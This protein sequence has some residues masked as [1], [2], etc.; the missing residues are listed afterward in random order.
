MKRILS[1]VLALSLL[2]CACGNETQ[3]QSR[4][5]ALP[6]DELA[7]A[8]I[9]YLGVEVSELENVN[10][11]YAQDALEGFAE[12]YYGLSG[13]DYDD[14][15]LY[16]KGGKEAF[17]ISIFRLTQS[18]DGKY[19]EAALEEYRL[20]R[21]GDFFGY[22][23]EQAEIVENSLVCVYGGYAAVLIC[24][25]A[26]SAR[27]AFKAA[28]DGEKMQGSIST[29]EPVQSPEPEQTTEPTQTPQAENTG[30]EFPDYWAAFVPPGIDNMNIWDASHVVS[31]VKTGSDEGLNKKDKK[32]YTATVEILDGIISPGMT[33]LEMEWAVYSWLTLNAEYDYRHYEI[34]NSAP[35]DS[36]KPHGP[37]VEGTA[38]C[39]GFAT[40][41]QFFMDILDIEC[42]TVVGAAFSS[43][44]DHAWNMVRIDGEW[45]CVDATW[46]LS[47][48]ASPE[49]CCYFNVSS[50]WM[51]MTDHQW[52]YENVPIALTNMDV[53]LPA[54]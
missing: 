43:R 11:T 22:A 18:A 3:T 37:I 5:E 29:S 9:S 36:Y 7:R 49:N 34:P 10:S 30:A 20:S 14:C 53:S 50:D 4:A 45:Y 28:V 38:V 31:A 26:E 19:I 41:F 17:E 54:A 21:Q 15:A 46:D 52:D 8:V 25:N 16:R 27:N 2:L 1:F 47:N 39:L 12:G 24:E 44:E 6:A 33:E 23:P 42:I 13:E 51:A 32:L 40:A 35:R 48:G